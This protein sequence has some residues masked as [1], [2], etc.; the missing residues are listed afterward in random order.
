MPLSCGSCKLE[1]ALIKSAVG[2]IILSGCKEGIHEIKLKGDV[3]P[4]SRAKDTSAAFEACMDPQK[5]SAPLQQCIAWLQAYFCDPGMTEQLPIP[6]FHHPLFNK[7]SFTKTVLLTLLKKVK[8]GETVT[9]KELAE[10]VGNV[11]A[12]RAVGGAMRSNPVPLIIPCHRVICSDGK[13]GNYSG[14]Q[15]NNVKLWLLAHEKNVKE[16]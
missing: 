9:Y 10:V 12:V 15:K 16:I 5:M 7:D 14:G 11:K 8:V 4:E 6:P 3:V 13:I 1:E 2:E